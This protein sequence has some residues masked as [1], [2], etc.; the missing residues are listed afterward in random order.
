MRQ[1]VL[2][3]GGTDENGVARDPRCVRCG[4]R[5]LRF[6]IAYVLGL[7]RELHARSHYHRVLVRRRSITEVATQMLMSFV[8]DPRAGARDQPRTRAGR[9][10]NRLG[11][12]VPNCL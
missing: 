3:A 8:E 4:R 2:R 10:R 9:H 6:A 5:P 12:P 7:S 11:F 1:E